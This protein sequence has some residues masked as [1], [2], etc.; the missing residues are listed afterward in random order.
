M[1][2]V[3]SPMVGWMGLDCSLKCGSDVT[4]FVV[5]KRFSLS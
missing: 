5:V 3:R 1:F 4:V 2:H